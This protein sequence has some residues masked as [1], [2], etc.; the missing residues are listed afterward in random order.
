MAGGEART[1]AIQP[2]DP[3][4]LHRS[5]R[6]GLDVRA[7]GVRRVN[8]ACHERAIPPLHKPIRLQLRPRA[9]LQ[10]YLVANYG[11]GPAF[12]VKM[13]VQFERHTGMFDVTFE[14]HDSNRWAVSPMT[15][16]LLRNELRSRLS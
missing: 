9:Q 13:L 12:P 15:V 4:G 1:A 10:E 11:T 5:G 7:R 8:L 3:T 2:D 14:D 16:G 6:N